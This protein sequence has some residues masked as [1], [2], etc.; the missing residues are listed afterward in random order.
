LYNAFG[1]VLSGGVLR[2]FNLFLSELNDLKYSTS[3]VICST[4]VWRAYYEGTGHAVDLSNPNLMTPQFGSLAGFTL[5][6][7]SQLK[8]VVIVPQT[9]AVSPQLSPIF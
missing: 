3:K 8:P 7:L 9:L 6:F 1:G 5:A 4:L 2:P